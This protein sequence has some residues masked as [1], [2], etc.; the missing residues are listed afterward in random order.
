MHEVWVYDSD[1][2]LG[3]RSGVPVLV[4]STAPDIVPA[5][6]R[7]E[8]PSTAQH[9]SIRQISWD[10][11]YHAEEM[12]LYFRTVG[13]GSDTLKSLIQFSMCRFCHVI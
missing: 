4:R 3:S 12:C 11:A 13:T 10:S 1:S 5:L 8:S 9:M 6:A 2:P 7:V